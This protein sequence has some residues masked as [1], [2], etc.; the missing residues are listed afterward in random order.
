MESKEGD[1]SEMRFV[2]GNS[3]KSNPITHEKN[4]RLSPAQL[5]KLGYK[6]PIAPPKAARPPPIKAV[7]RTGGGGGDGKQEKG[8]NMEDDK[9]ESMSD[10]KPKPPSLFKSDNDKSNPISLFKK[11]D[12][13]T[14]ETFSL[15]TSDN[16][17]DF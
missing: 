10:T 6:D 4:A 15:F 1:E 7:R 14:P 3:A 8:T 17:M 12:N 5:A 2:V 16:P 9:P 11:S 13:D